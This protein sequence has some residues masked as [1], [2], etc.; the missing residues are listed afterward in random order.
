MHTSRYGLAAAVLATALVVSAC[1]GSGDSA[2][3]TSP[4]PVTSAAPTAAEVTEAG[5][6]T[7]NDVDV[8]FAQGMIPHHEQAVEM[9][10]M[11]L[12]KRGIDPRVVSLANDIKDAQ[13]PEIRQM[14][15]WLAQWGVD[16]ASTAP[17]AGMPGHDMPGMAG[18]TMPGMGPG[19]G[20]MSQQD[21]SALQNAQGVEA[22]RLFLT[23]MIQHHN[24][25]IMMAQMEIQ[26]G[27]FPPAVEMAR[28][29]SSS[30]QQEIATMQ[31]ILATL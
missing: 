23:Q 1:G 4:S 5:S 21:M 3:A 2:E 10:D 18:G 9:S 12:G 19:Q 15:D 22:S 25:A 7:H 8:N 27:Q 11:V 13:G 28:S 31:E 20:M 6:E 26:G 29:I 16:T 17:A 30:Q 14:Q 24:G